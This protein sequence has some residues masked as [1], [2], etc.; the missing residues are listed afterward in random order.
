MSNDSATVEDLE[1]VLNFHRRSLQVMGN[2]LPEV[3]H[4]AGTINYALD[5]FFSKM[6]TH[7]KEEETTS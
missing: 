7:L 4:L 5:K 6:I 3:D 2:T 1:D